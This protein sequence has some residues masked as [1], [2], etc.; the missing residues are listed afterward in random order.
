MEFDVSGLNISFPG[1]I[2]DS[3]MP[4]ANKAYT[5]HTI[6]QVITC[7]KL[8]VCIFKTDPKY[9]ALSDAAKSDLIL[10]DIHFYGA[11]PAKQ[12]TYL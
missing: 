12:Y 11:V 8:L 1:P 4:E 2:W 6:D 9:H 3:V 7:G 5:D 10:S